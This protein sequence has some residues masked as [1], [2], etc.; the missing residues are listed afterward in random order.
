M[1]DIDG[2]HNATVCGPPAG[3]P[4]SSN[5]TTA[6]HSRPFRWLW[7]GST[8]SILGSEIGELAIP[9]LA[10]ISLSASA[11]ELSILRT[12]Q[13]LPFLIAT[14]PLGLLVDRARRRPLMIG[15]DLGRFVLVAAIPVAVW[16]G[17]ASIPLI[18][19]LL[20]LVGTLT[21]LYQSA[22]FALLPHIVTRDQL[23]DANSKL[24]ATIS[25]AEISGRGLGGMLVQALTAPIAVLVN[26]CGYL[27]SALSLTRVKVAEPALQPR[28]ERRLEAFLSGLRIAVRQPVLR[29]FL[30]GATTFNLAYEVF[31]LCVMLYL[32][33]DINASALT[34][35]VI[36]S[37][38]GVGSLFGAWF[39][40]KL[41][42]RHH[43]GRVLLGTLALGNSAPLLVFLTSTAG[44]YETPLM[45][46]VFALMG[47]GMG[48][49]AAHVVTLRQM[50]APVETM[51]RLNAAYRL[52]SWGAVPVG[53]T[54][55]GILATWVGAHA[56]MLVGAVGLALATV[57]VAMSPVRQLRELDDALAL[58]GRR[59]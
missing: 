35:G 26:A 30:A 5:E 4:V 6:W 8:M 54:L 11:S 53:A 39:G 2:N 29:G 38:G 50:V 14:L 52:V 46:A 9:L 32:V 13:F 16:T 18:A 22:D 25:A 3:M 42:R 51:G 10:L 59:A 57:W 1:T 19:T 49:S 15:A 48:I 21:V 23:T 36:L 27:A 31:L 55:G 58:D 44:R 43:Y 40:P 7:A 41:S 45:G 12:A 20:L 33:N 37:C 17:T 47:L 28:T 34:V 56:G 24:F